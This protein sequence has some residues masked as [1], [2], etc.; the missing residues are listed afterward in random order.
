MFDRLDGAGE[1]HEVV[2]TMFEMPRPPF[3]ALSN[4]IG[5]SFRKRVP[6][7]VS[8]VFEDLYSRATLT[9]TLCDGKWRV[10]RAG[11]GT[12]QG[13]S[14]GG[15]IFCAAYNDAVIAAKEMRPHR[16]HQTI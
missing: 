13:D 5:Q 6:G 16:P 8:R 2:L 4:A 3:P 7:N 11:R 10:W 12:R 1:P 15:D 14:T 9:L